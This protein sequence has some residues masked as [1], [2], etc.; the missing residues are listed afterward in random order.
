MSSGLRPRLYLRFPAPRAGFFLCSCKER[1][2]RKHAPE[3]PTA[4][5]ASRKNRR[6]PN[7][8]GTR[9]RASGSNMRLALPDFPCDARRRLRGPEKP[10]CLISPTRIAKGGFQN[11]VWRARAPQGFGRA[12]E[13][14]Q[15]GMSALAPLRQEVASGQRGTQSRG[16]ED[17]CTI[18]GVLSLGAFSLHEQ[19]EGTQG[20]GAE[21]PAISF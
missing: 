3:P 16:G 2:Q 5:C 10:Y 13:G 6:S 20:A 14:A 21:Q 17:K 11:P 19:R 12:P 8:P 15:T 18:R 1:S 7:S 9:P 4:S